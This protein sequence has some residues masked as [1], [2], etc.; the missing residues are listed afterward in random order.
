M[1]AGLIESIIKPF[2]GII[3]YLVLALFDYPLTVISRSSYQKYMS[4]YVRYRAIETSPGNY[5]MALWFIVKIII[6]ILLYVIWL[7]AVHGE[8]RAAGALYIWLLGFAIGLY[9]IID[10]RHLES[11]LLSRLHTKTVMID[12]FISIDQ[13]FS[14]KVSAI[15]IFTI[16]ILF[17]VYA[18]FN[19]GY[20]EL[21]LA[22]SPLFLIIRNHLL[23][24][25]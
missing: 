19:P 4:R 24:E 10:I 25:K 2:P 16:F 7:I 22:C 15:Q 17:G 9:L 8:L 14:L 1:E 12:G 11:I 3:I 20:F 21:G 6:A 18:L 23:S 13:R 5:I